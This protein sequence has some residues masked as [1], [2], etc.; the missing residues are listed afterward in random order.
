MPAAI[1]SSS[2]EQ[3]TMTSVPLEFDTHVPLPTLRRGQRYDFGPMEVGHSVFRTLD[4]GG[5][6]LETAARAHAKRTNRRVVAKRE[7]NAHGED[8]IRVFRVA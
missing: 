6:S 7:R 4:D 1:M 8:G 2:K 5:K 3:K